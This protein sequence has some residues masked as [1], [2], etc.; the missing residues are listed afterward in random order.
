MALNLRKLSHALGAEVCGL[1]VSKPMSEAGFGEI[2]QAFLRYN[3][4]LFRDQN[5]T[6]EQ[7]IEFSRRF[8]ELDRHDAL[9]RDRH[10]RHPEILMVT[11]EPKP[12]GA[13]SDTKYTG[14]QWHSDMSFTLVPSLGSLLRC[15]SVP[16][17]GGDTMFANMYLAYETLSDGMKRLIAGLHGIHLSGTRKIANT[18]TGVPRAEEQRR[19]NPPVAQPVVRV[20]PE[21]GRKALYIGEKVKRFEGMTEEESKPLIDYLVAHATRPEFVY[22]HRWRKDDVMVW[23]NRCTMHLALGDF[24]ETQLRHMERTTVLG[25]PSGR[26]AQGA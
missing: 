9:P 1:D 6:R 22:R 4:L 15:L 16:E 25:T 2:Y 23:D 17:V 14:R 7:H 24:D 12:D 18:E 11:N 13:P 3:I 19:I 21:T 26:V 10:P 8:G 20:H 5:I